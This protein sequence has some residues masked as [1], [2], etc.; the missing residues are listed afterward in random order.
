CHFLRFER[1]DKETEF[2]LFKQYIITIRYEF[3]N[4]FN[5]GTF[6]K[7]TPSTRHIQDI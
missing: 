6:P 2:L 1:L 3:K 5:T 7:G 4:Y